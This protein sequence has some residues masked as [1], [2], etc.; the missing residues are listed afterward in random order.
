MAVATSGNLLE[1]QS[2]RSLS[3]VSSQHPVVHAADPS[4]SGTPLAQSYEI[5]GNKSNQPK[6]SLYTRLAEDSWALEILAWLLGVV[7]PAILIIVLAV[8]NGKP[9]SHWHSSVSVNTL[10][11]ALTTIAS[12]ALIFPI[13]SS[14]AQLRWLWLQKKERVVANFDSFG[15]GPI[16]TFVMVF[17]HPKTLLAYLGTI[18]VVFILLFSPITQETIA[19]PV[20]TRKLGASTGTIATSMAYVV[21]NP[22]VRSS[23]LVS[24]E[25][26][27]DGTNSV[28]YPSLVRR[29]E[30]AI[31]QPFFNIS[32]DPSD[33]KASCQT[34]N[35]TFGFYSTMGICSRVDDATPD[36]VRSCSRGNLDGTSQGCNY[37]VGELRTHPPWRLGKLTTGNR[38][39]PQENTPPFSLWI[40]ASDT[41][42]HTQL[43]EDSYI[44][45][46]LNTLTEFYAIYVSDTTVFSNSDANFSDSIVALKGGLDLCVHQYDTHMINGTT[47]TRKLNQLTDLNWNITNKSVGNNNIKAISCETGGDEYWLD[48]NTLEAFNHFLGLEIF[49]GS[50]SKGTNI[51]IEGSGT[52]AR[53]GDAPQ[54]FADLLVNKARAVGQDGLKE[55]LNNLTTSMTNALRT[56]SDNPSTAPGIAET[57]EVHIA[58]EFRWLI[59]PIASVILSLILLS[60]VIF[61]TPRSG[62]PAWKA[63]FI[64][65][66]LSLD[67]DAGNAIASQDHSRSLNERARDLSLRLKQGGNRQWTLEVNG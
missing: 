27:R 53:E 58:V 5:I 61:E 4:L 66:L 63:S 47:T 62:A 46:N 39:G 22:E 25:Q 23:V 36:I 33:V 43:K 42:K 6:P 8:F 18:N 2:L 57:P 32:A 35:C 21:A 29:M 60:A 50:S 31:D 59:V 7:T 19:L 28:S 20:K 40:G 44:F 49:R 51:I 1:L 34:S 10:V 13:A 38:G 41:A 55:M 64:A 52:E 14:I 30:W 16:A 48:E 11:N 54:I 15:A 24:G 9:L 56:T 26:S 45:P 67:H 17:K 3:P 37:T 12:T 65:A